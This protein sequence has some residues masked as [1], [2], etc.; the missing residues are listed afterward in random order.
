MGWPFSCSEDIPRFYEASPVDPV[1]YM[2][3][4][5]GLSGM[6]PRFPGD[7]PTRAHTSFHIETMYRDIGCHH[8]DIFLASCTP[9]MYFSPPTRHLTMA[10][11]KLFSE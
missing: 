9:A 6:F 4:S 10:E 3:R 1:P 7:F 2:S 5:V 8:C 11:W